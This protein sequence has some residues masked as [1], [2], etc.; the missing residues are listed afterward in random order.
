[1]NAAAAT[2]AGNEGRR[3]KVGASLIL[4]P[5]PL[6]RASRQEQLALQERLRAVEAERDEAMTRVQQMQEEMT[7][8]GQHHDNETAELKV[9]PS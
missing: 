6:G 5:S 9:R 2:G 7:L 3:T 8:I 1:M 4:P